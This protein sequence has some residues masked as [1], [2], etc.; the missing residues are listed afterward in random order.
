M[1]YRADPDIA[2]LISGNSFSIPPELD[3]D[4][5]SRLSEFLSRDQVLEGYYRRGERPSDAELRSS[6]SAAK[7]VYDERTERLSLGWQKFAVLQA[8]IAGIDLDDREIIRWAN[9]ICKSRDGWLGDIDVDIAQ[10]RP[11]RAM[12]QEMPI[13]AF[14][15]F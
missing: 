5:A 1:N 15:D 8:G 11:L 4:E 7:A 10:E 12:V 13:S 3:P 2:A 14:L 9:G 6:A